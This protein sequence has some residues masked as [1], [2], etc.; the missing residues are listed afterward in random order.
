MNEKIIETKSGLKY[1]DIKEGVGE[2]P[3]NGDMVVVHYTGVFENGQK[4]D[5]SVDRGMPFKF[6]LGMKQVIPGWDE[7]VSTMKPGGKRR[8]IIPGS[9]G[10]GPKGIVDRGKVIIPPNATLIFDVEFIEVE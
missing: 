4:F 6:R 9:L 3:K 7:G 8:L 10:Y 5:S 1:I 2:M